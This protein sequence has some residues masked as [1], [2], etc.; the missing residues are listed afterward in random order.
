VSD[1]HVVR[2][3]SAP[4]P[5][6]L[7]IGQPAG[8]NEPGTA[9]HP[10]WRRRDPSRDVRLKAR[11]SLAGVLAGMAPFLAVLW[12]VGLDPFRTPR[13]DKFGSSFYDIQARALFHGHLAVPDRILGIESF[14]VDGRTY[15]YFPPFPA[16]LRM[17]LLLVTDRFDG[18]L[19]APSMLLAWV[20]LACA[21]VL[22]VWRVRYLVRGDATVTRTDAMASGL[23]IAAVT[24]ALHCYTSHRFRGCTTRCTCGRRRGPSPRWRASPRWPCPA[25]NHGDVISGSSASACSG[26]SSPAPPPVGRWHSRRLHSARGWRCAVLTAGARPGQCW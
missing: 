5:M 21:A 14:N 23:L 6:P 16:L 7:S 22:L 13:V 8:I 9:A 15:M 17:P 12:N 18:R 24:G 25:W 10:F 3:G 4:E 11:A 1:A 20:L 2:G 19:T 26:S